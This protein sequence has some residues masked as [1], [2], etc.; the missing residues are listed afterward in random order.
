VS[1]I[2]DAAKA[3]IERLKAVALAEKREAK[4]ASELRRQE[5]KSVKRK[6]ALCG[7]DESERTPFFAHPEGLGPACKEL[8]SCEHFRAA[9]KILP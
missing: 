5:K 3:E 7:I 9:N 2:G 4:R 8:Q 1:N 6:C